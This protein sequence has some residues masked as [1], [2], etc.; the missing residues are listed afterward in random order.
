MDGSH[1]KEAIPL[2]PESYRRT[3]NNATVH[4]GQLL[5]ASEQS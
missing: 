5:F 3:K 1:N 2:E 4:Y